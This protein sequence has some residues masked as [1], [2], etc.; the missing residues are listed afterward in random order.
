[1]KQTLPFSDAAYA[2]GAGV[3]F[4]GYFL[5]EVP[6]NLML[7]KIGAK[8][9]IMRITIGWGIVCIAQ[10]F[11]STPAEFYF[12]RFLLGVFEAG[13]YPGIILYLTY[14]YPT[15]RRARAFGLF[16]SASAFAGVIG[17][18]LAGWIMN[19]M[20]HVNGWSGWQ[21]VFL[22]EG[23]PSVI[24]GFVTLF[25]LTDK[26]AQ[27]KWLSDDEKRLVHAEL[28]RDQS[29]L[30]DRKHGILESLKDP[31]I[32]LLVLVYFCIIAANSSLTFFAPTLVKGLGFT[33]PQTIG[34]I[35]AVVYLFGAA[36]MII[37]GRHSDHAKEERMHCGLAALAGSIGITA[38]A[39]IG[40]VPALALPALT[41][42]VIGTMSAIPVFWQLPN[43][44]LSGSAAACGI[45]LINSVANLAGFGAPWFLGVVKTSTGQFT[46]GLLTVAAI[47]AVTLVLILV[48]I[49]RKKIA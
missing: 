25:Y 23:I 49:P 44:F 28:A 2:F 24:M 38:V 33:D 26:P 5:F 41:L 17:G 45:A 40:N 12:L 36:G 7:E 1:M 11:V 29:Q 32:W 27:A 35:M 37:N 42:A 16:M 13:F 9:T 30:G 6:S 34:W 10:M 31:K 18:P 22:L 4:V 3:F 15:V 20:H 19:H 14:W 43:L 8:K 46:S 48:F 21:W 39:L 47:E